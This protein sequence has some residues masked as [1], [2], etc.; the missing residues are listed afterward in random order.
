MALKIDGV[1]AV[2]GV[3]AVCTTLCWIPQAVKIFR[4][5]RT[6]GISVITQSLF[7]FGV[8][9]WAAYGLLLGRWPILL[10]NVVT[11]ALSLAILV[12]KLRYS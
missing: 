9:L 3:A 12:L 2:G 11:L 4:E 1:E 7:T 6:E 5:R 10:A 8:L